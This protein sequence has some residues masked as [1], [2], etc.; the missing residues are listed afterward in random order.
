MAAAALPPTPD[1]VAGPRLLLAAQALLARE[2]GIALDPDKAYLVEARL[3]PLLARAGLA[4][5]QLAARL[6]VD[7][8]L[9]RAALEALLNHET[10]FFRDWHPWDA[11]RGGVLAE[12]A[13]RRRE[14]RELTMWS[15]ACATGQEPY[16]LAM[17]LAE[18]CPELA[19]WRVRLL[20]TDLSEAALEQARRGRYSTLQVNR[21]LPSRELLAHFERVGPDAWELREA[22]RRRVEFRQLNLVGEWGALPPMDLVLLRNVLIYLDVPERVRLLERVRQLLRPDGWLVLGAAE[23]TLLLHPGYRPVHLGRAVLYQRE[24]P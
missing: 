14:R 1:G 6:A 21:G 5:E 13:A 2:A 24:G 20:A 8:A 11:L 9:R 4:P 19:G 17:L 12:L 10:S 3:A 7:P 23:T 18:A 15:A 16:S 22:L